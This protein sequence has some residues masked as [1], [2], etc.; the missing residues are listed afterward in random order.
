MQK[1]MKFPDKLTSKVLNHRGHRFFYTE[2][3]ELMNFSFLNFRLFVISYSEF[4]YF[5]EE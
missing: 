2:N 3:T 4:F 5:A 1:I